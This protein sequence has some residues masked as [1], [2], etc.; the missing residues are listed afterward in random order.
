MVLSEQLD[1]EQRST[2]D[3]FFYKNQVFP[4]LGVNA[5]Y[6]FRPSRNA[7]YR[8]FIEP[9]MG[10]YSNLDAKY[11]VSENTPLIE[12]QLQVGIMIPFVK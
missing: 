9:S 10:I 4:G 12:A 2:S 8:L 7:N 11:S 6:S 5:R 1:S 3:L